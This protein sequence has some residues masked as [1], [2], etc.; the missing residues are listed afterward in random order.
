DRVELQILEDEY[1][2]GGLSSLGHQTPYDE[3]SVTVQ[4]LWGDNKGNQAQPLLLSSK[5]RYVWSEEPIKY[6]F[7][8][9]KI[10]VTTRQGKII[11]GRS[12]DNLRTAYTYAAKNFFPSNGK[13]PDEMLFTRPQYNT[14]IELNY[15]Q[16][17]Q[18]ILAYAQ[19]L[20]DNGYPPG[21]LM[22]DDTW[23]ENYGIW[24]FAPRRFKDPKGMIKKLHDM[25]FKVML[26]ICPFVSPD[27]E[28]F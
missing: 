3:E 12:G 7:D 26:W 1:W 27:S 11:S 6:E 17:E 19:S 28:V 24:E 18:G 25:G 9:G 23:Q 8:K 5:G 2:W 15:N 13:I 20:I 21:V 16:H 14:W 10:R 4:D 22:I